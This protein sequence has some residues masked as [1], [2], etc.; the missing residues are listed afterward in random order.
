MYWNKTYEGDSFE[1]VKKEH[2]NTND[3]GRKSSSSGESDFSLNGAG[4]IL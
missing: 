1:V 3:L 4:V 2:R